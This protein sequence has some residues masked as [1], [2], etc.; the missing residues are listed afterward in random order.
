MPFTVL[1]DPLL[2]DKYTFSFTPVSIPG[3]PETPLHMGKVCYRLDLRNYD[4]DTLRK[5]GRINIQWMIE[6]YKACPLKE[7]F[8][9]YTQSNQMGNIDFRTGDSKFKEQIAAGIS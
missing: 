9:D 4:I 5:E 7:K 2:K 1:G 6:M 3:M 8:F